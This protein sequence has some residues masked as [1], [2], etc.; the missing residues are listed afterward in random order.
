MQGPPPFSPRVGSAR[1]DGS[2]PASTACCLGVRKASFHWL[3]EGRPVKARTTTRA[4]ALA[5]SPSADRPAGRPAP[6]PGGLPGNAVLSRSCRAAAGRVLCGVVRSAWRRAGPP[7]DCLA[8]G[9]SCKP[10]AGRGRIRGVRGSGRHRLPGPGQYPVASSAG[11]APG[12]LPGIEWRL[13][14]HTVL[15]YGSTEQRDRVEGDWTTTADCFRPGGYSLV[16]RRASIRC[17]LT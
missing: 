6:R 14:A 15:D 13:S 1:T 17:L 9:A 10:P 3:S 2:S 7:R 8:A 12:E 5:A 16:A 11:R 4:L